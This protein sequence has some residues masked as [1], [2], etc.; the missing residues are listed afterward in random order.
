MCTTV[1]KNIPMI[2]MSQGGVAISKRESQL[3]PVP[4]PRGEPETGVLLPGG[5]LFVIAYPAAK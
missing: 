5:R 2:I 3:P 1:T 4:Q